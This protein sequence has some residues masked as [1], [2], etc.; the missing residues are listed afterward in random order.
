M[1]I[2]LA[3]E[4]VGGRVLLGNSEP[5]LVASYQKG[6]FFICWAS[7]ADTFYQDEQGLFTEDPVVGGRAPLEVTLLLDAP[8]PMDVEVPEWCKQVLLWSDGVGDFVCWSEPAIM[9]IQAAELSDISE[10]GC[11]GWSPVP[12]QLPPKEDE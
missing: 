12:G 8:N 11:Q 7:G 6:E 10:T 1:T 5:A 9:D 2:K 3:P 4:H